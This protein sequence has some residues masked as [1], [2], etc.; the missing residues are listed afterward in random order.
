MTAF[1]LLRRV[2]EGAV[3]PCVITTSCCFQVVD[4]D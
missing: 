4:F 2:V 3:L 1:W